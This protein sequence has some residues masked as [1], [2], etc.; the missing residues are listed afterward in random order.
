MPDKQDTTPVP[1]DIAIRVAASLAA[2]ISLLEHSPSAKKAAPSD[3]MFDQ[4]L[5]DYRK[6]LNDFRAW[7]KTCK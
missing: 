1:M 3:R 2:A 5:T 4:M 7:A 6:A